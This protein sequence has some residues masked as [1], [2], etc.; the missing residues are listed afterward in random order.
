MQR[1]R[2]ENALS[3]SKEAQIAT[4]CQKLTHLERE[5]SRLGADNVLRKCESFNK[6]ASPNNVAVVVKNAQ[7]TPTTSPAAATPQ[8]A[9]DPFFIVRQDQYDHI[10]V[11]QKDLLGK[12]IQGASVSYTDDQ[13]GKTQSGSMNGFIAYSAYNWA[14]PDSQLKCGQKAAPAFIS[15]YGIG[16]FIFADGT[17]LQPTSP[18]EKSALRFGFDSDV[19]LCNSVFPSE[20]IQLMPY[21]QTD[22][23]GKAESGGVDV[24]WEP[25]DPLSHLGGRFDVITPAF[26]DAYVRVLGEANIF[27]VGNPGLTNFTPNTAYALL[28]GA[29]EIRGVLFQNMPSVGPLLCGRIAIVGTGHYWWDAVSQTPLYE[30]GAEIDYNLAGQT[31]Y[32][33]KLN[34]SSDASTATINFALSYSQGTDPA[35]FVKQ[36][37]YKASLKIAF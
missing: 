34:S 12:I 14:S 10:S 26:F 30:Y 32:C 36:N 3:A 23:R 6:P 22:F 27:D 4:D 35:T 33:A 20:Q 28:G 19:Y 18:K 29:A 25:F 5:L 11:A 7:P 21:G 1:A 17:Y 16:P 31:Q 24:L 2:A 13:Q 37:I 8:N 15:N 9:S